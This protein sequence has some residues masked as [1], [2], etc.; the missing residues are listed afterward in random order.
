[1]P[2]PEQPTPASRV[3]ARV[4][5]AVL[6]RRVLATVVVALVVVVALLGLARLR[7]NFSSTAFYGDASEAATRLVAFQDRWGADDST[8]LVLVHADDHGE[9]GALLS[10]EGLEAIAA[11][12]DALGDAPQVAAVSSIA[13][14][15][16]PAPGPDQ[17]AITFP[18]LAEQL[19]LASQTP[20]ARRAL[21]E[22]LPIVPT[23]LSADGS[24]TVLVVELAFSSDD[25]ARTEAAV[26]ELELILDAHDDELAARGLTREL[27][28]VPAIRAAFF[29]LI[30][31]D[32]T[33]FVP[34]TLLIIAVALALVFRR[35][36]GVVI[37]A[38]AA[39]LP[40]AM[41][42][43][44]MGWAGEP[45]GLLNQVYFTLLPVIAVADA[46]HMVA[47]FHEQR[48][49]DPKL[50][51]HAAIVGACSQVGVACLLT[52]LTTAAGFASLAVAEMPI[53]R[54]F[55]LWAA[56]G[57]VLAFMTGIV[58][59][60]LMLSL[61]DAEREPPA[62][63][64]LGPI[65][66]GVRAALKRPRVVVALTLA[67]L[68]LALIP[69]SRVEVDNTLSALIEAEHP[70]SVASRRVDDE[71]G[72]VLGLELELVAPP[73]VDLRAPEHLRV[74]HG[75]EGWLAAQPEVRAVEGLA[76]L[77]AEL[78]PLRAGARAIPD[79]RVEVDARL[80]LIEAHGEGL[81]ALV[82]DDGRRLRIHA[83]MPDDG[84]AHF[85]DFAGRAEAE[86]RARLGPDTAISA[87][88][89]GTALLAYRGVNGITAGLRD[90]FAL[91]FIVVL[92]TIAVLFRSAWPAVIAILPNFAPLLLGYAALGLLARVLDPLAAV[93]LTL[94]LGIAVDD[95]LHVLVRVR[96]ELGA[97]RSLDAA[98]AGAIHHSGMAVAITS[99]VIVGGLLLDLGSSFPALQ[100]L[101]L[102]GSITI[103][104]ALVANLVV[105]PAL[106]VLLRGRGL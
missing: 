21:L 18:D 89:T 2:E 48:R 97:G 47:R 86:L 85:I 79:A 78:G 42:V 41:L 70:V 40:T 65:D 92:G 23:L 72:G 49:A 46:I 26:A 87:D 19:G 82:S 105:L 15:T 37:P 54:S 38:L 9:P 76:T 30:I 17:R 100:L 91:V 33:I 59:V 71:F 52:S 35:V 68:G 29:E 20:A 44:I 93:I 14:V 94:A 43:G 106:V 77:V 60:P 45:I 3:L 51:P 103:G 13:S 62:A 66:R 101:G 99:L 61:V 27:A 83:G 11:L 88:A 95:T 104:L 80:A 56:L 81:R 28:G 8:L 25:I 34:A 1:M 6:R 96:E 31:H 22:R 75:F 4:I 64:G 84:G 32:Q 57:V 69:A 63:R 67:L 10:S 53:L 12:G 16:L 24:A 58:V 36:H 50:E 98:V 102:L 39:G 5:A 74:V 73:G 55:G 7:V 90:S